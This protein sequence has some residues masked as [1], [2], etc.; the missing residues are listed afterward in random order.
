MGNFE[1]RFVFAYIVPKAIWEKVKDLVA[2]DNA[3]MIGSGPFKLAEHRQGEFVRLE[4]ND[5]Y[6]G[7]TTKCRRGDLPDDP[8][9][10]RPGSRRSPPVRRT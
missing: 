2:F 8:E 4:A 5:D 7:G 3:E 10:R 9:R 6:S 1:S